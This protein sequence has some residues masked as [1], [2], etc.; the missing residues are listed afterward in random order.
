MRFGDKVVLVFG[1]NS[2]IGLATARQ[3]AQ[4][5]ARVIITGRNPQTLASA[6]D[7]IPG[8]A[9]FQGDI[10]DPARTDEI[11]AAVGRDFGRIDVLFVNAGIGAMI[12]ARQ[13]T[14]E[15]WDTVHS[16][17]LRGAFF[18]MQRALA[19]MGRGSS[20][21]VTGS[22]ASRKAP[23]FGLVYAAAKAGLSSVMRVLAREVVA[24]GI[25]VNMVS[26]GPVETPIIGRNLGMEGMD[27]SDLRAH[28]KAAVPMARIGEPEEVARAVLFLASDEA[29]FITGQ[30]LFVDGGALEL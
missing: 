13:V 20:I 6:A 24:D 16:I 21:V 14:P 29:S 12:P 2:G 27:V 18:A 8:C 4:E 1:G 3:F 9:A 25:R 22:L 7:S 28:S 11:V 26:P 30:E 10:A 15:F 19:L 5:G 17:N 23:P